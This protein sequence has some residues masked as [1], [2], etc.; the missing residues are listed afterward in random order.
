MSNIEELIKIVVPPK[1]QATSDVN[2]ISVEDNLGIKLPES[3][4]QIASIYGEGAFDGFLWVLNP[5][6]NNKNLNFEMSKYM[7]SAYQSLKDE[8]PDYY[9]RNIFPDIDSFF[10]WAL[11]D[12]GE[13]LVWIIESDDCEKWSIGIHS[14]DQGQEEVYNMNTVE[15]L[16][17]L[18]SKKIKSKI[19][20]EQFPSNNIEFIRY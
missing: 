16:Y 5:T 20:P 14:A 9:P 19:L 15:F 4:K 1:I 6:G 2:W 17:C 13:T 8:F 11:T 3:Y 12:N 18:F 10:P 7:I